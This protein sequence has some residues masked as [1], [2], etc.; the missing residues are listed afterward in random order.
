MAEVKTVSGKD[1][2]NLA[3]LQKSP[4]AGSDTDLLR[5]AESTPS[6]AA[7]P[8]SLPATVS[9]SQTSQ[10]L[11]SSDNSAVSSAPR[12]T[13]VA[14]SL[15]NTDD[16]IEAFLQQAGT[17]RFS[18]TPAT[19]RSSGSEASGPSGTSSR[20]SVTGH[21]AREVKKESAS[22]TTTAATDSSA[23]TQSAV[24]PAQILATPATV[25]LPTPQPIAVSANSQPA[26]SGSNA[27]V[28]SG[29][30]SS[31][32]AMAAT[33]NPLQDA[34]TSTSLPPVKAGIRS[35]Q[36]TSADSSKESGGGATVSPQG[37]SDRDTSVSYPSI[38]G[39]GASSGKNG[40][41]ALP[42][43]SNS[44]PNPAPTSTPVSIPVS[45][46]ASTDSPAASIS[47]TATPAFRN[48]QAQ[49]VVASTTAST[50]S[51]TDAAQIATY[52]AQ[53]RALRDQQTQT[54]QPSSK[55][56]SSTTATSLSTAQPAQYSSSSL[57]AALGSTRTNAVSSRAFVS[58]SSANSNENTPIVSVTSP[59]S[60]SANIDSLK[61]GSKETQ[62][63]AQSGS[64]VSWNAPQSSTVT[65]PVADVSTGNPNPAT[66]S[67]LLQGL[68][69]SQND[70][71]GQGPNH[72]ALNT[73]QAVASTVS[74][75]S[76]ASSTDS[77]ASARSERSVRQAASKSTRGTGIS[78]EATTSQL[79]GVQS[80]AVALNGAA[81]TQN[82]AGAGVQSGNN[83]SSAAGSSTS[84]DA[85]STTS[86]TFAALDA[87]TPT[88]TPTWL[89]TGARQAEAGFKDPDLGW[90]G[91]RASSSGG[92]AVHASLVPGSTDASTTLSGH[93]EGL[94]A[95]LAERHTQVETLTVAAPESRSSGQSTGL[96]T[97]PGSN[98]QMNQGQGHGTGQSTG[99]E[100][101]QNLGA[102][103]GQSSGQG[104]PSEQYFSPQAIATASTSAEL[105]MNSGSAS[106]AGTPA[107]TLDATDNS[108]V[109]ISV[110]A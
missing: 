15:A 40:V 27:D 66:T 28:L 37:K 61:Q 64:T 47:S 78:S 103:S 76:F 17:S 9:A 81:G 60:S 34:Q 38:P 26:S 94:N 83:N 58:A 35:P 41:T 92:G 12:S 43:Q 53:G 59:A 85:E 19:T 11:S 25:V 104:A 30:T 55:P 45:T 31:R 14:A 87:G 57:G 70:A 24:V 89:S 69:Q 10:S 96:G 62:L 90:I 67:P 84:G 102:N 1:A 16:S 106:L 97:D 54:V 108:G 86:K 52:A 8:S 74:G 3:T 105:P 77:L 56:Q 93:L 2:A 23:T 39:S 79:A 13:T 80:S 4:A 73:S 95:F 5:T 7:L 72:S 49:T 65:S 29:S 98:Q 6:T 51:L 33:Q 46:L 88:A 71:Q 91:V 20:A 110:V 32:Y 36:A 99:Q 82:Q 42:S 21:T 22:S 100:M 68:Q 75:A 101:T 109:H 48:Q 50:A 63:P 44:T 107:A 18:L